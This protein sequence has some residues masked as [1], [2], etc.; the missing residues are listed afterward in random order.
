MKYTL[1]LRTNKINGKQYV[2]Q[3][4][5]F[6][7]RE[8]QWNCL[9]ARYAN[10]YIGAEREKYGVENFKCEILAE[11]DTR[12]VAWEL[13]KR[14]IEEFNTVYPNGYN[15]SYGGKTNVG[16]NNG[17]HNGKEFE[18]GQ[19]PWNK[20]LKGIHLSPN[21]EFIGMPVVQLKDGVVIKEWD[22][23]KDAANNVDRC[24]SSSISRCCKGK[25]K[26]AGGYQWM[27]EEDYQKMLSEQIA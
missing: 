18:K 11:V 21:T 2:G 12:E 3:T 16:G 9:K 8:N 20:N 13:E 19:T 27:Y 10:Q 26:S 1:Y 5:D 14:Y 7:K 15:R 23:I 17:Y 6:R 24:H 25:T 22:S 4:N